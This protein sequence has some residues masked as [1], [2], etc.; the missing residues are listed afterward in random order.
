MYLFSTVSPSWI[1]SFL[2]ENDCV[3]PYKKCYPFADEH[4]VHPLSC[5][6]L[7]FFFLIGVIIS[8]DKVRRLL[9]DML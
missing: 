4:E 9:Y 6:C 5:G 3:C 7:L 2:V 1:F 8:S